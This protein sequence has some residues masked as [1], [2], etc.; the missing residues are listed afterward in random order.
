[1]KEKTIY[2]Q[3]Q[4]EVV[5]IYPEKAYCS[6]QAGGEGGNNTTGGWD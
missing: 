4:V 3:P 6:T 5:D 2:N 1:M